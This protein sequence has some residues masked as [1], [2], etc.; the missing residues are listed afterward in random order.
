M[1]NYQSMSLLFA[2][3]A[4]AGRRTLDSERMS[5]QKMFEEASEEAFNND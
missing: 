1:K 2:V 5:F 4:A 3:A